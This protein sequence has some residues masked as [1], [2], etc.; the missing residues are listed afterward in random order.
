M[1]A[2]YVFSWGVML[3]DYVFLHH[4]LEV[5]TEVMVIVADDVPP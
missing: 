5:N 1:I 3:V 2:T 4:P